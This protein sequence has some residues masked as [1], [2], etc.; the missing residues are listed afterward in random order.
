MENYHNI[1]ELF[2]KYLDNTINREEYD[3]LLQYFEKQEDNDELHQLV[4]EALLKDNSECDH[5]RLDKAVDTVAFQLQQKLR[6]TKNIML[7]KYLPY[8]AAVLLFFMAGIAY[9]INFNHDSKKEMQL[10]EI[11]DVKPGHSG[12]TLTLASGKKVLLNKTVNGSIASEDGINIFKLSDS[13]VTYT[14]S[15]AKGDKKDS[16]DRV[17]TITTAKGETYQIVLSDSTK[18]WLN[19]ATTLQYSANLGERGKRKVRLVAGEAY[20][21]VSKDEKHPFIVKT[22]TQN[23]EVLGTHFNINSYADEGHT[24]TTLEE[25][26]VKVSTSDNF[27]Q[28]NIIL[29][30]GQQSL[31]SGGNLKVME[32]DLQTALAWKEGKIYFRDA[33]IQEVLRQVSRWYNIAIEYNGTPTKELFNGGIKRTANLSSVLRILELSN[34]K[35]KLS[36]K[37]N[38]TTL[39]VL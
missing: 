21:E 33:P 22:P 18:V 6:P 15:N 24:V 27:T 23:V 25:G 19:A 8:A 12:A 39:I 20:F 3:A 4:T 17:N 1:Q 13:T 2:T 7:R 30:P 10:V 36:K 31:A 11:F 34:V 14:V 37:N 32:A 26:S 29:K 38:T 28:K 16:D 35:F 9:Y 5:I